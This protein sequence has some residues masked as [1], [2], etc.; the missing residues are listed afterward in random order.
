MDRSGFGPRVAAPLAEGAGIFSRSHRAG[1]SRLRIARR[2]LFVAFGRNVRLAW[3][4]RR[5]G[6]GSVVFRGSND[7]GDR[8][9]HIAG[10]GR[11]WDP[12]YRRRGNREFTGGARCLWRGKRPKKLGNQE[13]DASEPPA[14]DDTFRDA[15]FD[16]AGVRGTKNNRRASEVRSSG[17]G[18]IYRYRGRDCLAD[19][20]ALALET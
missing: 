5:C 3:I 7:R 1:D 20:S 12:V 11:L 10:R 18:F 4:Y 9:G 17:A 8:T 13:L 16:G 14:L 6:I 15:R 19:V 2:N